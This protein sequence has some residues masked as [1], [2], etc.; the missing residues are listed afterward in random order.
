[1]VFSN[2]VI[3]GDLEDLNAYAAQ[4][5]RRHNLPA[6]AMIQPHWSGLELEE[7][8]QS[9]GFLGVKPYLSFAPADIPAADIRIYDFL[10]PHQ[11]DVLNRHGWIV[12]LHIPRPGRLRDPVNLAQLLEIEQRYPNIKLIIAHVGRAYCPEDIGEAF[13][14]LSPT[15]RMCFDISANTNEEVF[16]CLLD[17]V[18]PRRVLFGSDMPIAR[19]RMRRICEGGRYVNLVPR[20]LYGDVSSDPQMRDVDAPGA[21]KLSFFLYEQI[22]AFRRASETAGL[23][24]DQIEDVFFNNARRLLD[25]AAKG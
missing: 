4:A 10:P 2:P 20:G 7:K 3:G 16:R 9:G 13:Q 11:L 25:A 23:K 8:I 19:M 12:M 6:L 1:M 24:A 5:A 15:R 21:G 14:T 22:N 17:A 18:G